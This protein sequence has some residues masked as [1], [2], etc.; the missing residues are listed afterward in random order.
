MFLAGLSSEKSTLCF[1]LLHRTLMSEYVGSV[2]ELNRDACIAILKV[3]NE[4]TETSSTEQ[5]HLAKA[6]IVC[7]SRLGCWTR[8]AEL[9]VV[10]SMKL[11]SV[12]TEAALG[13][14][15]LALG[16]SKPRK[17]AL[18]E[19][20]VASYAK[21]E[22][23]APKAWNKSKGA[24]CGPAEW[25]RMNRRLWELLLPVAAVEEVLKDNSAEMDWDSHSENIQKVVQSSW[26]GKS[27]F[28]F[29][30]PQILRKRIEETLQLAVAELA[31]EEEVTEDSF[32]QA[33]S[34]AKAKVKGI[35][36]LST[37]PERREVLIHYR[38]WPLKIWVKSVEEQVEM[39][40]AC[41]LRAWAT[42]LTLLPALPGETELCVEDTETLVVQRI[43]EI[44]LHD[45]QA[46]RDHLLKVMQTQNL[47]DG[48][49]MEVHSE[50]L[51]FSSTHEFKF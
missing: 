36:D 25:L 6:I 22:N 23:I 27:L 19:A 34:D 41:H 9:K 49:K 18:S 32:M 38:G 35:D 3:L 45:A 28:G 1:E 37:L 4:I 46:S 24:T 11:D 16:T 21:K 5:L 39:T 17:I 29:A 47:T 30:L 44:L 33:R 51:P 7:F 48:D 14:D 10:M 15:H 20:V 50:E 26:L 40:F 8:H 31:S 13:E 2:K 42:R 43:A 12:I